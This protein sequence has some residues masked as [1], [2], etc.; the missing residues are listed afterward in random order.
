MFNPY[1][2]LRLYFFTATQIAQVTQ[3]MLFEWVGQ[4][5]QQKDRQPVSLESSLPQK[6]EYE[7]HT[8]TEQ[9]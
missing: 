6:L 7:V 3:P 8:V 2:S 5:G 4:S 1:N 9:Y